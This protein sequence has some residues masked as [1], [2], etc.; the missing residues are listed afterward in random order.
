MITG[1]TAQGRSSSFRYCICEHRRV[2]CVCVCDLSPLRPVVWYGES[3]VS[4]S[5]EVSRLDGVFPREQ[6][7]ALCSFFF[8]HSSPPQ[9]LT[10]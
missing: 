4:P 9:E 6:L 8:F 7:R 5:T 1:V 3:L 2:V 10:S